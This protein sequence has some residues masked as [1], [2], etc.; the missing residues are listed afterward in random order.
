MQIMLVQNPAYVVAPAEVVAN[1]RSG[2]IITKTESVIHSDLLDCLYRLEW[3]ID[4]QICHADRIGC[5]SPAGL[6]TRIAE[7]CIIEQMRA[8][9]MT[10]MKQD[11]LR[12]D[13][14]T[15]LISQK[16]GGIKYR[17]TGKAIIGVS[18]REPVISG[19]NMVHFAQN[20]MKVALVGLSKG[21]ISGAIAN[22]NAFQQIDD[23]RIGSKRSLGCRGHS[24]G[25]R[26]AQIAIAC[27]LVRAEEESLVLDNR[28]AQGTTKLVALE[29]VPPL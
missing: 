13:G 6:F 12:C 9:N 28:T 23:R 18:H 26:I 21:H 3:K 8:E 25:L 7:A 14:R 19:K 15:I 17:S 22:G 24:L 29:L 27:A 4:A 10:L 1:E 16:N 5:R 2:R 20:I 11:V